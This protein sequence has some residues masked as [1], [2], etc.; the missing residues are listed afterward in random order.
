MIKIDH[1]YSKDIDESLFP[2]T[3]KRL[4]EKEEIK[5]TRIP[6]SKINNKE[7][8]F[9]KSLDDSK[10]INVEQ[11]MPLAEM[12][13][14]LRKGGAHA[15]ANK[16]SRGKMIDQLSN[17]KLIA[18]YAELL[19]SKDAPKGRG[20]PKTLI[21]N[22]FSKMFIDLEEYLLYV[23]VIEEDYLVTCNRTFTKEQ[24]IE[25]REYIDTIIYCVQRAYDKQSDSH[26]YT[27][28]LSTL[29][30]CLK[31]DVIHRDTVAILLNTHTDNTTV[32]RYV[33]ASKICIL[34]IHRMI[35]ND[36]LTPNELEEQYWISDKKLT[37]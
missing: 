3:H 2:K 19:D 4:K 15:T 37:K 22:K 18:K 16:L 12:I 26:C 11:L 35:H 32:T 8:D 17:P 29:E 1:V 14:R 6:R 23:K 25:I 20:R 10:M 24:A 7:V 34:F 28:K 5:H 31:L 33:K 27:L 21:E 13:D 36:G 30:T 9:V